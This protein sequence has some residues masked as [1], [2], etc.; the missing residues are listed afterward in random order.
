[1]NQRIIHLALFSPLC[2]HVF[3]IWTRAKP[4]HTRERDGES[5]GA[6]TRKTTQIPSSE[7]PLSNHKKKSFSLFGFLT[8]NLSKNLKKVCF[9]DIKI[10]IFVSFISLYSNVK[11]PN[12]KT[13]FRFLRSICCYSRA[14]SNFILDVM[15]FI[16]LAKR[17]TEFRLRG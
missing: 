8:I 5:G 17:V 10:S 15:K 7:L 2:L 16:V 9:L 3:T 6:P 1:M 4:R 11:I 13:H 12:L 14:C